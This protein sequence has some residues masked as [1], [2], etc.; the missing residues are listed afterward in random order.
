VDLTAD[1]D[2]LRKRKISP[3]GISTQ[4]CPALSLVPMTCHKIKFAKY[5][6]RTFKQLQKETLLKHKF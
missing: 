6:I 3:P 4:D 5:F 2:I 1:F